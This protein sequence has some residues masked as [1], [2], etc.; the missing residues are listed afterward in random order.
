MKLFQQLLVAPAALGLLAPMAANADQ[1]NLQDVEAGIA[2]VEA[3]VFSTTTKLSGSTKFVV[4]GADEAPEGDAVHFNYDT[5]LSLNTSF[6]GRDLLRTSLR[7]GN[8]NAN[9]PFGTDTALLE[10]SFASDGEVEVNRNFYRFPVGDS[11]FTATVGAVVRQDDMLNVWPSDYPGDTVLDVMT[12][13]GA[14]SVYNLRL[15]AGAGISYDNGNGWSGSLVYVGSGSQ[16]SSEGLLTDEAADDITGQLAYVG[17]QFGAAL[18]YTTSDSASG[19]YDAWGLSAYWTPVETGMWPSVSGG[20][21]FEDPE[22]GDDENTWT[23][24]VQWGDVFVDGNTLGLAV[25]SAESWDEDSDGPLAYEAWYQIA[26]SD[27]I[28]VTPAVFVVENE[29]DDDITGAIVKTTFSF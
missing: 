12:Y 25:G 26:V 22:T 4:G 10:T 16:D 9:S 7:S 19:D 20:V 8:F 6:N 28:T 18:A 14:P 29:D 24:G 5:I 17:D 1:L 27:N 15:G 23:I 3:G 2:T 11:A 21:G 13:A